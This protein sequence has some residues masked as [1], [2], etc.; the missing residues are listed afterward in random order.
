ML[1]IIKTILNYYHPLN[2]RQPSRVC[3]ENRQNQQIIEALFRKIYYTVVIINNKSVALR[4][5]NTPTDL[6][7]TTEIGIE[8]SRFLIIIRYRY[9][10]AY[11]LSIRNLRT[12]NRVNN[13]TF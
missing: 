13:L 5:V 4:N 12:L 10:Y 7:A 6:V 11:S 9:R 3:T 2:E 8:T 1:L